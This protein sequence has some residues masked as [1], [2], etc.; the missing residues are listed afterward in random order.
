MLEKT[1][2]HWGEM[3][4]SQSFNRQE[5]QAH[6]LTLQRQFELQ[7]SARREVEVTLYRLEALLCQ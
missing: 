2:D 5:W 4:F 3:Y 6:P 7:G 1:A